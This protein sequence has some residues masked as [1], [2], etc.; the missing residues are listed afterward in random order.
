MACL[1]AVFAIFL[2][3]LYFIE[4]GKLDPANL[5]RFAKSAAPAEAVARAIVSALTAQ[6]AKTRYAVG[7][8]AS[9]LVP[10]S[11]VLP[12]G[13]KDALLGKLHDL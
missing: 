3:V 7:T 11:R 8:D 4:R 6:H 12:D 2:G 1:V 10:L 13:A 9:L 5:D